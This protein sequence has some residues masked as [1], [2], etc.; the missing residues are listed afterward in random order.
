MVKHDSRGREAGYKRL[1][2]VGMEVE[3]PGN[4]MG[5]NT[6]SWLGDV[7]GEDYHNDGSGPKEFTFKP[8]KKNLAEI[9]KVFADGVPDGQKWIWT[10]NIHG[11]NSYLGGDGGCGSHIH[12]GTKQSV[13]DDV[14]GESIAQITIFYNTMISLLPFCNKWFSWGEGGKLRNSA[15]SWSGI[16]NMQRYGQNTVKSRLRMNMGRRDGYG[17]LIWNRRTKSKITLELRVNEAMPQW[18]LPFVD[19]AFLIA[20]KHIAAGDSPKLRNHRTLMR[21]IHSDIK[22]NGKLTSTLDM[23]V[24]FAEGRELYAPVPHIIG[25]KFPTSMSM[26][27]FLQL[28][29]RVSYWVFAYSSRKYYTKQLRFRALGGDPT[30]LPVEMMWKPWDFSVKELFTGAGMTMPTASEIKERFPKVVKRTHSPFAKV[31]LG[32]NRVESVVEDNREED[33]E[34]IGSL[35]SRYR[36]VSEDDLSTVRRDTTLERARASIVNRQR[37][38]E[39]G[40]GLTYSTLESACDNHVT[41]NHGCDICMDIHD[42]YVARGHACIC[43]WS[44]MR[45]LFSTMST[46]CHHGHAIID[47]SNIN[48]VDCPLC[49]LATHREHDEGRSDGQNCTSCYSTRTRY[50]RAVLNMLRG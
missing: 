47:R 44:E 1:F 31:S 35:I 4:R 28:I 9:F 33:D 13:N 29:D 38:I 40:D 8:A 43:L 18:S 5:N 37:E 34:N 12:F 48:G 19:V 46:N 16:E 24:E 2:D 11:H 6:P 30:R 21:A 22:L 15:M 36:V 39:N 20:N 41:I 45:R 23:R 17:F 14:Q 7:G 32:V 49:V 25:E 10:N 50:R 3:Q 26:R 27:E 42:I